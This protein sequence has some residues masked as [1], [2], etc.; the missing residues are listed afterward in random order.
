MDNAHVISSARCRHHAAFIGNC[1]ILNSNTNYTIKYIP[2][3]LKK[4]NLYL[5]I[6]SPNVLFIF[7]IKLF[8]SCPAFIN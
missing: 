6:L 8:F 4:S 3:L 2:L 7:T 1:N 5:V